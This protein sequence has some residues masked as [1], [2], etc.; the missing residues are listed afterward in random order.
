[1]DDS[2]DLELESILASTCQPLESAAPSQDSTAYKEDSVPATKQAADGKFELPTL[3][4][5][6][7][8][9]AAAAPAN[10]DKLPDQ[11]PLMKRQRW[12]YCAKDSKGV[13]GKLL[14]KIM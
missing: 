9:A 8:P 10:V 13:S 6:S 2:I 5:A 3:D 14:L 11:Q 7:P 12:S 4:L 1:M